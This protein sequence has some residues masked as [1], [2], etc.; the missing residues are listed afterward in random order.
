M[1]KK[2]Y[3][4]HFCNDT[5][6]DGSPIPAEGE[7]LEYK[8]EVKICKSG[9]HFSDTPF[10][11]LEY[12]PGA[13]LCYVE[14]E[15]VV[16]RQSDKG[17]CRRRKIIAKGDATEA[18]RYFARMQAL[19]VIHLA[20]E[21]AEVVCDYLATGDENLRATARDTEWAA[22]RA[23]ASDAAIYAASYAVIYAVRDAA[24]D[25]ASYAAWDAARDAFNELIYECFEDVLK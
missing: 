18:L 24:W 20:D 12:A 1:K 19:S 3:G 17:V 11:A 23:A 25:A 5:L 16:E 9:L 15:D 2:I 22:A 14:L 10:D 6:R 8:G 21:P 7:W 13:I 4:W